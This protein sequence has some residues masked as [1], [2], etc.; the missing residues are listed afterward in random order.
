[1]KKQ[2]RKSIHS[3]CLFIFIQLFFLHF[4]QKCLD[5]ILLWQQEATCTYLGFL[6][7]VFTTTFVAT[8]VEVQVVASVGMVGVVPFP[9]ATDAWLKMQDK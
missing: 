7:P 5:L 9:P 2:T 1:M 8:T 6:Q 4:P 3:F